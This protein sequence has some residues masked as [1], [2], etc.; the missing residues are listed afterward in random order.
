MPAWRR[1]LFALWLA[2]FFTML[3]ISM[4]LPF[5]PL[6]LR[7][8]GVTE[9]GRLETMSGLV[10]AAPFFSAIVATPIWGFLGDRHGRKLM[11]VR[12]ALGLTV[13]SAL[14]GFATSV[15]QLLFLRLFQGAVSG[16]I[17][18]ALALMASAA[19]RDRMGYALGTL[20]TAIPSGTIVGPLLG[21]FLADRIGARNVFFVTAALT[22][23]AALVAL[24][25][26]REAERPRAAGGLGRILENYRL[27]FG[28]PQ[29]RLCFLVLF[30]CQFALM[31]LLPVMALFVE[32]LGA[33][34]AL[35]ATTTGGV[36]AVTG[37]AN[38]VAAP[39]WGR[40]SDRCGY[41]P[42]LKRALLGSALF[43]LP[44]G[45]V[46]A[47]WQLFLLR[48]PY[49][50]FVGGVVPSVHAMVG[51]RA[52]ADRRAG[53]MGVT[54]TA[55]MVGNLL[56]PLSGGAMAAAFGLRSVF[57][58]ATGALVVV[59]ALLFPRIREPERSAPATE[60]V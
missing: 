30:G 32:E 37:L 38:V 10:F 16:F 59:L 35:L 56:G 27:V 29:L 26:V 57:F 51:L 8:L 41:T 11:V 55:L 54:S 53:I 28:T 19:P 22:L 18:A 33:H 25:L 49:G 23:V 47:T 36:I 12:A 52:P 50:I 17:A 42:T 9:P 15:G 58:L 60:A 44:Q 5:L 3:G 48:I 40:R 43:A 21:G 46:G 13:A 39:R 45:L 4:F 1:T 31:A 2:E 6:Y 14:M 20:Q 24:W 34:G 7:Q